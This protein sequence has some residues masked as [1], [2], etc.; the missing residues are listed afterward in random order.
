MNN[1]AKLSLYSEY[2]SP[3]SLLLYIAIYESI[4]MIFF[5]IPF[6]F[7]KTN[8]FYVQN[9]SVF[10]GFPVY[11]TGIKLFYSFCNIILQYFYNLFF[12][13]L[14]DRFSPSHL[15]L[16]YILDAIGSRIYKIIK[17]YI[18]EKNVEWLEYFNFFIFLILFVAAMIHNEIIIINIYG[19]NSKTKYIM[20]KKF[21]EETHNID[22]ILDDEDIEQEND[23]ENFENNNKEGVLP[24]ENINKT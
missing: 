24:L 7:L 12:M 5:S 4:F 9:G 10:S 1:Y 6:I 19:F 2:L 13:I 22:N 15:S 3:Y 16:A 8:D 20:D 21:K 23:N 11:M 18:D 14:I 17:S